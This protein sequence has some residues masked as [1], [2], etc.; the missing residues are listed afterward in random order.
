MYFNK[1]DHPA[2]FTFVAT[3]KNPFSVEKRAFDFRL[4]DL[5]S[6]VHRIEVRSRGWKG[7][8]SIAELDEARFAEAK[9]TTRLLLEGSAELVLS[10]AK[11]P[12]FRAVR[13]EAFG[14]CGKRWIFQFE[15]DSSMRFYGMGEK[16]NGFEKSGVRTLFWNTDV[17]G[18][19]SLRE[20]REGV[21][22]PMYLSIP[23]LLIKLSEGGWLGVLINNPYPV[24][25]SVGAADP[26]GQARD[27]EEERLP[28]S[29]GA[30]NGMPV[31][32]LIFGA[33]ADAVTCKL[34]LLCGTTSL[35]P[36]WALGHHQSRW[37]YR[38]AEDL[39]ELDRSFR[40]H[41]IPND[42][43]WL[44][45]DY[46]NGYRIFTLSK[47]GFPDPEGA[48]TDLASRGRS[49]VAILDP[50]VKLDKKY[51]VY[52]EG[53]A[54]GLFCLTS[55]GREYVGLV[56]PGR[57]VFPDFSLSEARLWW[58]DHVK[59]LASRGIAGFWLD[60]NDPSTGPV[61]L[62]EM[63]FGHGKEEHESYHNQYALGMQI[64][65]REGLLAARP[66]ERPFLLSRSAFISTSRF[67]AVWTGDNFSNQHHL[68]G[69]IPL[70][71]N[72]SLSG[73]PF[74]GCDV[75][76]FDGDADAPLAIAWY[77][78][79][80]LFPFLRNHSSKFS[81]N[82]EPWAFDRRTTRVIAHY[83][84][85]RY[86]LLPYLYNLF[87][88]QEE[89]GRPPL[90]PLFYEF[91]DG[92]EF[93]RLD[94]QFMVGPSLMQAPVLHSNANA[95]K[96]RLPLGRWYGVWDRRWIAGGREV[97]AVQSSRTTPIYLREGAVLPMQ[98]G[99]PTTNDTHLSEIELH[100]FVSDRFEGVTTYTYSFD[101]G[102][103]FAYRS[104]ARS[105]VQF[106]VTRDRRSVIVDARMAESGYGPLSVRFFVYDF[107]GSVI[108]RTGETDDDIRVLSLK[109]EP[110]HFAGTRV[111]P[112]ATEEV[113]VGVGVV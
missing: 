60:M 69:S 24:F 104:G 78:A 99:T 103:S 10:R 91:P 57:T 92:S 7:T 35:P 85:L 30:S 52:R 20:A 93:D 84:G 27:P 80:F 72:L 31:F 110:W 65:S 42:G 2:N 13:D 87:V 90:R 101:D 73:V 36:L 46:M 56:W 37:G 9:S 66:D 43:L 11:T 21:T 48:F 8:G 102:H 105:A 112:L 53:I 77:K 17:M 70:S 68:A 107:F 22:D 63:R 14:V 15:L 16:N 44:D 50:G 28:L 39:L 40:E 19:F 108:L 5:G 94:D 23:Y 100:L 74:N 4:R 49:V 98:R 109:P 38:S 58:A 89:V 51:S 55:E 113:V 106:S 79:C 45:I 18:D 96:L 59:E 41:G 82:Q 1:I 3:K 6:D 81:R 62:E 83:I 71:I 34:Q 75:P 111:V 25:M 12:L 54:R 61:T 29:F 33:T 95:R 26:M 67:A 97:N 64:A 88:E 76:G 86:K 32:Y 47:E